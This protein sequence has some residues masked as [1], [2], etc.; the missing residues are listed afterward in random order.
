MYVY[1]STFQYFSSNICV[2]LCSWS[3]KPSSSSF[4]CTGFLSSWYL[5]VGSVKIEFN[6][7][8]KSRE[9]SIEM[10]GNSVDSFSWFLINDVCLIVKNWRHF[11]I[12]RRNQ[13]VHLNKFIIWFFFFVGFQLFVGFVLFVNAFLGLIVPFSFLILILFGLYTHTH[14]RT[15]L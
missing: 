14:A 15:V 13:Q 2:L 10:S 5:L 3:H 4:D 11:Q 6:E 1:Y 7:N 12:F 9:R 8:L